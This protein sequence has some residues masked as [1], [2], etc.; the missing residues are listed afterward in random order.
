MFLEERMASLSFSDGFQTWIESPVIHNNQH[1]IKIIHNNSIIPLNP[2]FSSCR[3]CNRDK[4]LSEVSGTCYRED[5]KKPGCY[6]MEFMD[7]YKM[8]PQSNEH[9]KVLHINNVVITW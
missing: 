6:F 8:V 7:G 3:G 1:V 4:F 5:T 9:L 2:A